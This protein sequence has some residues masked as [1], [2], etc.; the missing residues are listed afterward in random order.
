MFIIVFYDLYSVLNAINRTKE[1]VWLMLQGWKW[2]MEQWEPINRQPQPFGCTPLM[3]YAWWIQGFST[4]IRPS[5]EHWQAAV[6]KDW[7]VCFRSTVVS[8]CGLDDW[9][10]ISISD[11]GLTNGCIFE[12]TLE[13]CWTKWKADGSPRT[14]DWLYHQYTEQWHTVYKMFCHGKKN[15]KIVTCN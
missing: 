15:Q 11:T 13:F 5:G 7:A 1:H 10:E 4:G 9:S 12:V 14:A 2:F 3:F 6:R 8:R